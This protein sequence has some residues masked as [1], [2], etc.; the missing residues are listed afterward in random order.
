MATAAAEDIAQADAKASEC[1]E[2]SAH[3]PGVA[4]RP[5]P[6]A[7]STSQAPQLLLHQNDKQENDG[8]SAALA[9]AEAQDG[10]GTDGTPTGGDARG[11][12]LRPSLNFRAGLDFVVSTG[13]VWFCD[14]RLLF[15]FNFCFVL[16]C[17]GVCFCFGVSRRCW[18]ETND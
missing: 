18:R 11:S 10:P 7:E 16:F 2:D 17:F 13:Q 14:L 12:W 1:K 3:V 5:L 6:A 4:E 8:A 15:C 9:A